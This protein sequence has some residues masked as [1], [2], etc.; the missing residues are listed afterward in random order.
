MSPSARSLPHPTLHFHEPAQSNS[1]QQSA[2]KPLS[3][4]PCI[5]ITMFRNPL[6][7]RY[8]RETLPVWLMYKTYPWPHIT[9]LVYFPHSYWGCQQYRV[10]VCLF[11]CLVGLS[12]PDCKLHEE[13]TLSCSAIPNASSST[14]F[15]HSQ[16]SVNIC[17]INEWRRG[18]NEWIH[19]EICVYKNNWD[20]PVSIALW[21]TFFSVNT[22]S[23]KCFHASNEVYLILFNGIIVFHNSFNQ[24]IIHL[25]NQQIFTLCPLS[26][27]F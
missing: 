10:Y 27:Q 5:Y 24:Y 15:T 8:L 26:A 20:Y 3:L 25:F 23:W 7:C 21:I 11:T 6:R 17:W 9:Y 22:M 2:V 12:P 4:L 14:R 13:G 16:S 1:C 18:V 19:I